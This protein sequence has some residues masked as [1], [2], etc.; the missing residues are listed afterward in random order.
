ML[1][2]FKWM[3]KLPPSYLMLVVEYDSE[4]RDYPNGS[5]LPGYKDDTPQGESFVP[6]KPLRKKKSKPIED[7][8]VEFMIFPDGV[9]EPK[10]KT[11]ILRNVS[12]T[13]SAVN[14][15]VLPIGISVA[16]R[17]YNKSTNEFE[18]VLVPA[19]IG[20][21]PGKIASIPAGKFIE[22]EVE[23]ESNGVLAQSLQ[24]VFYCTPP[25]KTMDELFDNKV[26]PMKVAFETTS[27][28]KFIV[29]EEILYRPWKRKISTGYI[30]R[31]E[32]K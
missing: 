3:K 4:D 26:F 12:T 14:V 25:P 27:G 18:E 2:I 24:D 32:V 11:I 6:K 8:P 21:S 17:K 28:R 7:T 15:E 5:R 31:E 16:G 19:S 9:P 10:K 13:E 20:F 1:N 23:Y 29:T 30:S 22:L